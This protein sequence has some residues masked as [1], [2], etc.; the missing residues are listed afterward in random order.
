MLSEFNEERASHQKMV[1]EFARLEQ[2]YTN[3]EEELKLEQSNPSRIALN[4]SSSA[5]I[6]N[7]YF[8]VPSLSVFRMQN[9]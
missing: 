3:L 5:G 1:K 4:K 8:R 6:G 7:L 9:G 2:R